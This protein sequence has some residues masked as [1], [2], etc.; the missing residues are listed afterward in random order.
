VLAAQM[1]IEPHKES[2]LFLQLVVLRIPLD[3]FE[4]SL[5]FRDKSKTP[6]NLLV[7]EREA[8]CIPLN[9]SPDFFE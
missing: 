8:L 2:K 7:G 5:T 9:K 1:K 3:F 6:F 4:I